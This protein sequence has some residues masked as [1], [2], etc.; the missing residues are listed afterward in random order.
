[1]ITVDVTGRMPIYEQ[2]CKCI[3]AD[4][5]KGLLNENDK[6]PG[7][8]ALAKD[9]GLNPNTVAKAYSR[10]EHDGIIYSVAGIGCFVAK[11]QS[12]VETRLTK[13][14]TEKIKEALDYGISPQ[15]LIQLVNEASENKN[16]GG[17]GK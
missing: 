7:A 8:R 10:L 1:M 13:E 14:L 5:A 15:R 9:L 2:I 12:I 4:I 6:L 17:E 11:Q 16:Q 3:C